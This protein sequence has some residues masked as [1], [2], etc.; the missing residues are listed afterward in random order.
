ATDNC[1]LGT[2]T[3]HSRW[4]AFQIVAPDELFYEILMRQR[5]Q[6]AKFAAAIDSAKA[7]S[8]SLV[9]LA[10]VE[11]LPALSR[12]QQVINRQVWQVA[13]AIDATHTE[14]TLND[15][16]T[17]AARGTLQSTIITPL[18][19]LHQDL[20]MRLRA[21]IDGLSQGAAIAEE[22]RGEAQSLADQSVDVMQSILAQMS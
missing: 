17:P 5:E 11:D 22:R 4:L 21:A 6:R 14:M 12:A 1:A 18:S 13:G 19:K 15:L 20:L 10:K 3:G 9:E 7:Q 16:G 8:K 2:Q